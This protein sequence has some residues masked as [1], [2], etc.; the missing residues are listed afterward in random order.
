[1][2]RAI[3]IGAF[4]AIVCT[5]TGHATTIPTITTTTLTL[6]A[7]TTHDLTVAK[8]MTVSTDSAGVNSWMV[9]G[10][11]ALQTDNS[12]SHGIDT[13]CPVKFESTVSLSTFS[14]DFNTIDSELKWNNLKSTNP[15][16]VKIVSLIQWCDTA[17]LLPDGQTY[18]GCGYG[19][20]VL[21]AA[22]SEMT[23]ETLAHEYGHTKG[24]VHWLAG[25]D[26]WV[27]FEIGVPDRNIVNAMECG[28]FSQ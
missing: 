12:F 20:Y 4:L 3:M 7:I 8:S 19:G 13:P 28:K 5:C 1:M 17:P 23:P 11:T 27:M 26:R 2:G 16:R 24:L 14:S 10:S 18:N 9:A 6:A 21:L 22:G 15:A 25:F